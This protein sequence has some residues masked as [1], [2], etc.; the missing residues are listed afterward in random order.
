MKKARKYGEN[1]VLKVIENRLRKLRNLMKERGMDY[2]LIPSDDFH[3]SEY[4]HDYFKCRE[5]MSGFSGSAGTL[6]V[7]VEAA[8]LWTDGRYFLQA[9]E[10]LAGSGITLYKM[11][12]PGVPTVI[13]FLSEGLKD[14]GTLGFDGRVVSKSFADRLKEK[15]REKYP[16][17][18]MKICFAY[19]EDLVDLVWADRPALTA[20]PVMELALCYAGVGRA[21]KLSL[22]RE[23]MWE[24]QGDYFLLTSLDDIAWLLNIRGGDVA[25]NPVVRA[26][27]MVSATTDEG[28]EMSAQPMAYLYA[29]ESAF[30]ATL[31]EGLQKD[32]VQIKPYAQIYDDVANLPDECKLLWDEKVINYTLYRSCNSQVEMVT[33]ENLTQFPKAVK[34]STEI[35][36]IRKAH[37]KDGV[38]VTR[39]LYWMDQAVSRGGVTELSAAEKLENFRQEQEHYFGQSFAPIVGYGAHGAIV[40]YSATDESNVEL[41]PDNFVL[42]DTGGQYLEGTTDITRTIALGEPT[43]EQ[44][45][46]YTAVLKGNLNLS[47]MKFPYECTGLNLDAIARKPLWDLGLDYNHGTGHGVGYFLNVHEGPNAFRQRAVTGRENDTHFEEGMVTSDEPGVYLEGKYGIRLENLILSR[48]AEKHGSQQFM[49]FEVLTLVPFDLR[50]V[51]VSMLTEPERL[52]LNAYH[53]RVFDTISPYLNEAETAWLA[54]ATREI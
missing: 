13:E 50:A 34:N 48:K 15:I 29:E 22:I 18:L 47:A 16:R 35:E 11:G 44:K 52:Y 37:V 2:F 32:G 31:R 27:F 9:E 14:G 42:I 41:R 24:K 25:Y 39:F 43:A 7:G 28:T 12:Q 19:G 3:G 33:C 49:C 17:A 26:Y 10:Q 36:N 46:H 1:E 20:E 8:G 45:Q 30:P 53:K 40:H 5:Y 38:A 21:D 54:N 6:V 23:K 4:V 51:D